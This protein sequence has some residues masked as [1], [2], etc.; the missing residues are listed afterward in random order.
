MVLR[1]NTRGL[2]E[3]HQKELAVAAGLPVSK[4]ARTTDVV[5]V[6]VRDGKFYLDCRS[7]TDNS[8]YEQAKLESTPLEQ[9]PGE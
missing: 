5:D 8:K 9:L 4:N 6:F 3:K 7:C 1:Y 2:A